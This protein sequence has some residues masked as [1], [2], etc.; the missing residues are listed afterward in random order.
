[1]SGGVVVSLDSEWI[2]STEDHQRQSP[3]RADGVTAAQEKS[4]R[5]RTCFFIERCGHALGAS[6]AAIASSVVLFQ[7]FY[8]NQSFLRHD[9]YL[10]A[11][12]CL[13]LACKIE[14]APQKLRSVLCACHRARFGRSLDDRSPDFEKWKESVLLCERVLLHTIN[15]E[16]R[17]SH[18]FEKFISKAKL[19]FRAAP[20]L[21]QSRPMQ[22]AI[23]QTGMNL[24]NDALMTGVTIH[25]QS[26]ALAA[27]ALYVA[28]LQAGHGGALAPARWLQVLQVGERA[29]FGTVDMILDVYD[30]HPMILGNEDTESASPIGQSEPWVKRPLVPPEGH[31]EAFGSLRP[32]TAAVSYEERHWPPQPSV[33]YDDRH[34]QPPTNGDRLRPPMPHADLRKPPVPSEA[35]LP[36]AA[37]QPLAAG[38]PPAPLLPPR[39]PFM[40][41]ADLRNPPVAPHADLRNPP[42]AP[43]ADLRNPPVAPHADLRKPPVAT[44]ADLRNPPVAPHADLRNPPVAPHADL[45][46]PPVPREAPEADGGRRRRGRGRGRKKREREQAR[47]ERS[48]GE[49]YGERAHKYGRGYQER[50]DYGERAPSYGRG[51]HE[52][53]RGYPGYSPPRREYSP[54][55]REYSPRRPEYSPRRPE[56]SPRRP[57]YSDRYRERSRYE[58]P[59]PEERGQGERGWGGRRDR[60]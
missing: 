17:I 14:E 23:L 27:A 44:H 25:S 40:P 7:R 36:P 56:Y 2:V 37:P 57:E 59:R 12:T 60:R 52:R 30:S 11:V 8:L 53:D 24:L 35:P 55:R 10:V 29:L 38:R 15:F 51:H 31:R 19:L 20:R 47:E 28:A 49:E 26:D 50:E 4:M 39:R 9:R 43:H 41:H 58:A 48:R 46:N 6:K 42:V 22:R 3:S 13:F 21:D 33:S 16:L 34:W 5:L 1:M 54:P 45:R 18:P 32:P